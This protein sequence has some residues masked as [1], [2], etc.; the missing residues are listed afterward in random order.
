MLR[1][2]PNSECYIYVIFNYYYGIFPP[3][4]FLLRI[5][6]C[7]LFYCFLFLFFQGNIC[8][9]LISVADLPLFSPLQSPMVVHLSCKSFQFF[10]VSRHHSIDRQVVWFRDQKVNPGR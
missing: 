3:C 8:P 10:Y 7:L 1:R 2:V 4:Y 6:Q 5:A 9:E